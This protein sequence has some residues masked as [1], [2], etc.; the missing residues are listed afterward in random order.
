M[1]HFTPSSWSASCLI[2]R[3]DQ[4]RNLPGKIYAAFDAVHIG[5]A[6]S[7]SECPCSKSPSLLKDGSRHS[8]RKLQLYLL[9][10][11]TSSHL[12]NY[13]WGF[14]KNTRKTIILPCTP[15]KTNVQGNR[16]TSN[17]QKHENMHASHPS[18]ITQTLLRLNDLCSEASIGSSH[19]NRKSDMYVGP[20]PAPTG[21][22]RSWL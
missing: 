18:L 20:A 22:C 6:P 12:D 17:T 10:K 19:R 14:N 5:P 8:F 1:N 15:I 13:Y 11:C 7:S 21:L 9:T 16:S 3:S 2:K 4:R